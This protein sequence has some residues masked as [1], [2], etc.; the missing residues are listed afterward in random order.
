M[1]RRDAAQKAATVNTMEKKVIHIVPSTHWDREWYLPFRRYQLRLIR[2]M[3]KVLKL[4]EDPN[5]PDFLL[6]GQ[7]IML[8]DYLEIKPQDFEKLKSRIESG[9]IVPG[10]WYTVPDMMIPCGESLI[11]NLEIG[12][13]VC[14]RFGG[15]LSTAY[16]PDSFGL[17][18]QMPQLYRLF[19]YR[20]ALFTRGLRLSNGCKDAVELAW[21]APDAS[22][23]KAVYD[24][25]SSGLG[26]A[27]PTVWRSF[28]RMEM[29]DADY[30]DNFHYILGSQEKRWRGNARLVIVG[31][32]HLEPTQN[33]PH[34]VNVLQ[35]AYP[36]YD[37]RFSSMDAFFRDLEAQSD[38]V[39]ASAQGE[40]RGDYREHFVLGNT[41]S[42]R[43]DIKQRNRDAENTLQYSCQPLSAC[44]PVLPSYNYLDTRPYCE[45]AWK[46]LAASHAHD[47]ICGCNCDEANRDVEQRLTQA[48]QM[49]REAE[50]LEQEQLGS[51]LRKGASEAAVVVYNPLPF[52][53]SGRVCAELNLPCLA[54]G[55]R[56]VDAEG[57]PVADAV[58]T[59]TYQKRRDIET[60]KR[61]EYTEVLTDETRYPVEAMTAQD[62]YTGVT[63]DFYARE[64]P[65]GGYRAYYLAQGPSTAADWATQTQNTL[66][67]DLLKVKANPNGTLEVTLKATGRVL[68]N[69]HW[70]EDEG[71]DGDSYTFS[72]RGDVSTTLGLTADIRVEKHLHYGQMTFALRYQKDGKDVEISTA[73]TLENH[74]DRLNFATTVHNE[75]SNH[76]IRAVLQPEEAYTESLSDSAFDLTARP[77]AEAAELNAE[78]MMTMPMRNVVCL[79]GALTTAVFS[80]SFQEYEAVRTENSTRLS[81]TLLRSVDKVYR[82]KTL[83][84]DES[85]CGNG[86]RW[87][88]Q[89]S[90]MHGTYTLQ[91]ALCFY[92]RKLTHTDILN[93]AL[94]FQLPLTAFGALAR[95]TAEAQHSFVQVQGAVY[96]TLLCPDED[97]R[98][99]LLRVYNPEAA[100][101]VCCVTLG[102]PFSSVAKVDL[103]GGILEELSAQNKKVTVPLRAGEIA[104]LRF[105]QA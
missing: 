1:F 56:L 59:Q 97:K 33:L 53:R 47:S 87:F 45:A 77:I 24:I 81:L 40:Q 48:G 100:A 22:T 92:T 30:I 62:Y 70:F 7:S 95:G 20:N 51:S 65:A 78:A 29:T 94:E 102:L 43:T 76:R 60:M 75:A 35:Q 80:K 52:A 83:T 72:P 79:P 67:N 91:Y 71:D 82:T 103:T 50:K 11:K 98:C 88:T 74:S 49:A 46:L 19:G 44:N 23:V 99:R 5:Y 21:R 6:D 86:V 2:L 9:K 84:K 55:Q 68:K 13:K 37:I 89:D 41:M 16:S 12:R 101:Q 18:A 63:V 42:T 8:E 36:D 96:S 4:T 3:E 25:Y 85:G 61:N 10:P 14:S 27:I 57:T 39:F 15:Q 58:V 104:T 69:L 93:E 90:L 34:V 31:I 17:P 105:T 26:L 28:D 38:A 73:I 54:P 64:I 32:D 66:E